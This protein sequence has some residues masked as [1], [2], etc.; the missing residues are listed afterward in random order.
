LSLPLEKTFHAINKQ[1]KMKIVPRFLPFFIVLAMI[2]SPV[3]AI[4][5][6][7]LLL[8][9]GATWLGGTALSAAGFGA[10]GIVSGSIAAGIQATVGGV[11]AGSLFAALQSAGATGA[12]ASAASAGATAAAAGVAMM[13]AGY[14]DDKKE[15][16]SRSS[17]K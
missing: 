4:F 6:L 17:C 2:V 1:I 9:G 5:P 7:L 8:G 11:A 15:S 10:T 3:E 16:L 13:A 12:I 14:D